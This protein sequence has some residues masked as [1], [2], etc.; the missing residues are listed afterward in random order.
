MPSLCMAVTWSGDISSLT[1]TGTS[2]VVSQRNILFKWRIRDHIAKSTAIIY[3]RNASVKLGLTKDKDRLRFRCGVHHLA[4]ASQLP[5]ECGR[6]CLVRRLD[7]VAAICVPDEYDT[8]HARCNR[9]SIRI[10]SI[11]PHTNGFLRRSDSSFQMH[12]YL[13]IRC[14]Y[15]TCVKYEQSY[16]GINSNNAQIENNLH[17]CVQIEQVYICKISN[18]YPLETLFSTLPKSRVLKFATTVLN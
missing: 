14:R 13:Q 10:R 12:F 2:R 11:L 5:T 9:I 16:K 3:P 17:C 4:T 15:Y 1:E 7:R 6:W 8:I 18:D